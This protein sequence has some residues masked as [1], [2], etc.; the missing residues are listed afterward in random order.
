LFLGTIKER[1]QA[2][3]VVG[4]ALHIWAVETARQVNEQAFAVSS[5]V[6]EDCRE[7]FAPADPGDADRAIGAD[8]ARER[9]DQLSD[10]K[11]IRALS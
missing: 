11:L 7:R 6:S 3:F 4:L 8:R 2:I 9:S 10:L 5:Y 1:I